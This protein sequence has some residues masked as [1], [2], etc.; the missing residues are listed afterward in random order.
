[1][2]KATVGVDFHM[3]QLIVGDKIIRLQLWD[4]AGQDRFG[5]MSRVYYK[6]AYG[7]LLV[8]DI[9]RPKT[10]ETV[11]KVGY[12]L[13]FFFLCVTVNNFGFSGKKRLTAK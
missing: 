3:K 13:S 7:A 4:I 11:A 5:A 1:M 2:H 8:Y 6:G 9:S 12:I 10:F